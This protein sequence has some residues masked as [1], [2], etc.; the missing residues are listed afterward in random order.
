MTMRSNLARLVPGWCNLLLTLTTVTFFSLVQAQTVSSTL[1]YTGFN[2]VGGS[3]TTSGG[4][5]HSGLVTADFDGDGKPDI[6]RVNGTSAEFFRNIYT[7]GQ[8]SASSYATVQSITT[9]S[10]PANIY[11][12]DM[13]N[14]SKIDLVVSHSTGFDVFINTSTSGTISFATKQ[15]FATTGGDHLHL[16][17]A[18][19]DGKLDVFGF[20]A[21]A[22]S[23]VYKLNTTSLPSS[24]LTFGTNTSISVGMSIF[25][26]TTVDLDGDT[27]LDIFGVSGANAY[28]FLNSGSAY[29]TVSSYNAGLSS[30]SYGGRHSVVTTDMNND[31]KKDVVATQGDVA[32]IFRN[33]Y[34]SGTFT[35][36]NM[37]LQSFP[38]T[39]GGGFCLNVI[40]PDLNNDGLKEIVCPASNAGSTAVFTN[41]TSGTGAVTLSAQ[42]YLSD[43]GYPQTV[44]STDIDGDGHLDLVYFRYYST[45]VFIT[46]F[47]PNGLFISTTS[48]TGFATCAGTASSNQSF[49]VSGGGLTSNITVTAPAGYEISTSA[50]SGFGSSLTLT[51]SGGVVNSTTIYARITSAASGA[52]SGN[53]TIAATGYTSKTIALSGNA[54]AL[55]TISVQPATAAQTVCVNSGLTALSLTAA[56]G[57]GTISSYQWYSNATASNSG[58]TAIAGANAASYTPSSASAGSNYYYCIVTNSNTCAK[59]SNVSGL[60]TVEATPVVVLSS[61][62]QTASQS[63]TQGTS[64]VPIVYQL[65][66]SATGVS[67]TGLPTGITNN[68]AGSAS[69]VSGATSSLGT[70]N[71]LLTTTGSSVCSSTSI[72]GAITVSMGCGTAPTLSTPTITGTSCIVSWPSYLN[73]GWFEFRYRVVGAATW[74]TAGTLAGNTTSKTL[75]GLTPGTDYEVQAKAYCS[76]YNASAWSSSKT[77]TTTSLTACEVAPIVSVGSTGVSTATLTW[78]AVSGAA[79]FAVRYKESTSGTWINAGTLSGSATSKTFSGLVAAT[80]YDFQIKSYCNQYSYSDWGATTVFSTTSGS[81]CNVA[82]V[83][84]NCTVTASTATIEWTAISGAAYYEFRY[85]ANSSSTWINA[86]TL[87]ATAIQKIINGLAASTTYNFQA[88]TYCNQYEYSDWS[89]SLNFTTPAAMILADNDPIAVSETTSVE[90]GKVI[91]STVATVQPA[92]VVYPNPATSLVNVALTLEVASDIQVVL[93]DQLGR[94]LEQTTERYESGSVTIRK[95]VMDYA[96]GMYSLQIFKDGELIHTAKVEKQ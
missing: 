92:V 2:I 64:I 30:G 32:Y 81:A 88:R 16:A 5:I 43:G 85:K 33:T 61:A 55:P 58:G 48:L 59:V 75:S 31:G 9:S 10:G 35:S 34:T 11:S 4:V 6:A 95:E 12:G 76:A 51:Q 73:A 39:G 7:S 28:F 60:K 91:E 69:T 21:G 89:N 50:S 77:F 41:T 17:D 56:A 67:V 74:T 54:N 46:Q 13:N 84:T 26:M 23:I 94:V 45:N 82:P 70:F 87:G 83:F 44:R 1:F 14:D 52:V 15:T 42:N 19:G 57:S 78:P 96:I 63:V 80:N 90:S 53:I 8:V 49:T 66:G 20:G 24:T 65:S 29:G 86:G 38:F 79:Y 47:N 18:N 36:A 3:N 68:V 25:D 72:N 37:T 93:V 27:D 71:Y 62:P 22:T 40:T